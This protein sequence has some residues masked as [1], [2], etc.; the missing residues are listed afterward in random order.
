LGVSSK[1]NILS[2]I[3]YELHQTTWHY[4]SNKDY[5]FTWNAFNSIL[6]QFLKY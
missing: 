6:I 1:I 5:Y 2:A 4:N 3:G